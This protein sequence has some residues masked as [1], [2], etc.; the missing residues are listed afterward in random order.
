MKKILSE[1]FWGNSCAVR[2]LVAHLLPYRSTFWL[3]LDNFCRSK[4]SGGYQ[5]PEYYG[6]DSGEN[7]NDYVTN[8]NDDS[9]LSGTER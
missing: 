3:L 7:E 2:A 6:L 5:C 4:K 9:V 1:F 8:D